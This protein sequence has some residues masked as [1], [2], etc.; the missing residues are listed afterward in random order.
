M[1][2]MASTH[3][4]LISAP[5]RKPTASGQPPVGGGTLTRPGVSTSLPIYLPARRHPETRQCH[6]CAN[7]FGFDELGTFECRL[8]DD[9]A[10]VDAD[11]LDLAAAVGIAWDVGEPEHCPGWAEIR[12]ALCAEHLTAHPIDEGCMAC[13][14][15]GIHGGAEP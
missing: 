5:G 4:H 9:A 7:S 10:N 8:L 1:Q 15:A 13:E 6:A 3:I 11:E 2:L 12:G 14:L